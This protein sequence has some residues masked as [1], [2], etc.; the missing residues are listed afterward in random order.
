MTGF[1]PARALVFLVIGLP[2]G[3]ILS[4]LGFAVTDQEITAPN[5]APYALAIAVLTGI[6]AGFWKT[7]E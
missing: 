4:G 5:I 3:F 1:S 7:A 2:I 6:C